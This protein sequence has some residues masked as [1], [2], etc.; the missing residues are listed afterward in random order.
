MTSKESAWLDAPGG[1]TSDSLFKAHGQA[2]TRAA[3]VVEEVHSKAA[4]ISTGS[5]RVKDVVS[6]SVTRKARGYCQKCLGPRDGIEA[7]LCGSRYAHA[8]EEHIP[9][10]S[11]LR[12]GAED[13][14]IAAS[15]EDSSNS[16]SSK[17]STQF[18]YCSS[19]ETSGRVRNLR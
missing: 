3:G 5:P 10:R 18:F 2:H 1:S 4:P 11:E 13:M 15:G 12:G 6:S 9:G 17:Y 7:T 8:G 14:S 19:A 16:S